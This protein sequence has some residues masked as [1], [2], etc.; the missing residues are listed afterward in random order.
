MKNSYLITIL[1]LIYKCINIKG[2]SHSLCWDSVSL[3]PVL[4]GLV[5][6]V[7]CLP[8]QGGL[9]QVAR[10]II[11]VSWSCFYMHLTDCIGHKLHFPQLSDLTSQS[12]SDVHYRDMIASSQPKDGED[13]MKNSYLI[14]IFSLLYKCINIKGHF[15]LSVLG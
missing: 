11:P 1:L 10:R 3:C 9:S 12:K 13:V 2:I 15:T 4:A 5:A 6:K 7:K 14:T 8:W